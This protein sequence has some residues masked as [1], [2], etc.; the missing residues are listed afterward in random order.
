MLPNVPICNQ[1][2]I[3]GGSPVCIHVT[4]SNEILNKIYKGVRAFFL[5]NIPSSE[6]LNP[7]YEAYY[8]SIVDPEEVDIYGPPGRQHYR[9]LSY[10]STQF[11]NCNIFDIGT[12]RGHSAIALAYNPSN[13]I[14]SFDIMD[15]IFPKYRAI[16]NIKFV[17][18][19]LFAEE[20]REKW[21]DIILTC[22]FIFLD[23]DPHN[24]TMEID[25]I[26][27]LKE[28]GYSG[29]IV[30]DDIWYFKEMRDNFW[31]KIEPQYKYDITSVGHFSGTGIVSF[32]PVS[33]AV[34]EAPV[35]RDNS[36]W[37][38]VTAYFNLTR[39]PDAS[40]EI[41]ARDADYYFTHAK[42]TLSLPY[43][44]VIYCDEESIDRIREIRPKFLESRTKYIVCV[45]DEYAFVKDGKALDQTF[46]DYRV[47]INENRRTHPYYFDNRNTASYYLFCMSR[48][49]M[50]KD[51]ITQNSFG[52]T[53]FCWINF[54]IERM[55]YNN[56]VQLDAA[57]HV[58]RDRFSTCYIDYIPER[59]VNDTHEYFRWG[60]CSMCSGFF[61]GNAKYMYEVCD[62]IENQFLEYLEQGYGHADEQLYSPVYFK[63]RDLFEHY[64]GDYQEM[65]TNYV[66]VYDRP[67]MPVVN[68]IQNSY[69]H[70]EHGKCYEACKFV[71]KS[72][73][74]GKCELE[75]PYLTGLFK[76]YMECKRVL[77][78]F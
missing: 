65:I 42:A 38:L 62:R 46:A 29:L 19:N 9:L 36:C 25:M 49:A 6:L 34:D 55:G 18:D 67:M 50:L 73:A 17:Y 13:T 63:N 14:Y 10:L 33:I 21:R 54:C 72:W 20:G 57:L 1:D 8:R 22:P 30:C 2:R 66:Y 59:L 71:Y 15:K 28:I 52:S 7:A 12:H 35:Q 64:Y 75:E 27:W 4:P 41:R 58:K 26:A 74:L 47:R 60:R 77:R 48:Y 78:D 24:G 45:F 39:A 11:N 16:R 61:T 44:L 70:G 53:H 23:V 31:H 69:I 51:T 37:T 32:K 56:L 40:D 43:N 3:Y 5:M 76:F 68:F